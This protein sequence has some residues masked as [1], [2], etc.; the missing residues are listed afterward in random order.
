[1]RR[2]N[3]R[4][5]MEI[6]NLLEKLFAAIDREDLE[7]ILAYIVY[8]KTVMQLTN[9]SGLT[10]LMDAVI[11][12]KYDA[13]RLLLLHGANA[14]QVDKDGWSAKSW[15]I[16]IQDKEAQKI[17]SKASVVSNSDNISGAVFASMAMVG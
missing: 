8:D 1:M 16:F 12:K 4:R 6:K 5:R 9:R 17:L 10:P 11:G 3:K 13:M 2:K 14:N 7:K 15:A